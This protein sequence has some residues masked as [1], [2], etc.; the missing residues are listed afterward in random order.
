VRRACHAV[1]Y[2]NQE[3]SVRVT[4][5]RKERRSSSHMRMGMG[6]AVVKVGSFAHRKD[7]NQRPETEG[8]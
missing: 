7:A 1:Q 8:N 6:H 4:E 5:T 3:R 2:A